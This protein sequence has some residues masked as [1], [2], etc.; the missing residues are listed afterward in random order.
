MYIRMK[1]Q[2]PFAFA[3]LWDVW[4]SPDG[5]ETPTCTIITG[6]PNS[7][8]ANIHDRMPAILREEDVARWLEPGEADPQALRELLGKPYPAEEMEATPVG[9]AV[10]VAT[11]EGPDC[12][13]SIT[14]EQTDQQ[15]EPPKPKD[16]QQTLF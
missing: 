1:S 14:A 6:R 9:K 3:G 5:S 11:H 7:L 8:V 4:R 10:N 15:A 13:E 12:I 16:P 2:R